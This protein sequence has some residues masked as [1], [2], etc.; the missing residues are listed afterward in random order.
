MMVGI[1]FAAARIASSVSGSAAV[2]LS[3]AS[4]RDACAFGAGGAAGG[5]AGCAV[6]SAGVVADKAAAAPAACLNRFR[7]ET[8]RGAWRAAPALAAVLV[9]RAV[10]EERTLA[11]ELPGYRDYAARVRYR[12]PG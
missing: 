1:A 4:S 10:L 3:S 7:R 11:Q 5:G 6:T 12:L 9:A 2:R 8:A